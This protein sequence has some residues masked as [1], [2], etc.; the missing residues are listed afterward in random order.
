MLLPH[1]APPWGHPGHIR[2]EDQRVFSLADQVLTREDE[3]E[4]LAAFEKIEREGFGQGVFRRF[5]SMATE[6][7]ARLGVEQ[8]A[9]AAGPA[10]TGPGP[11]AGKRAR[12]GV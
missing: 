10:A 9:P 3:Q 4:L 1:E 2:K 6:L 11:Q 8:T 12:A 7:A 5:H